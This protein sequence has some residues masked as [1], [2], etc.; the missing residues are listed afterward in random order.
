MSHLSKAVHFLLLVSMLVMCATA[1][2]V[3]RKTPAREKPAEVSVSVRGA[4]QDEALSPGQRR[5]LWLLVELFEEV[6]GCDDKT[7]SIKV[8]AQIAD[9]LWKYDEARAGL[10]FEEA[11][12]AID[13]MKPEPQDDPTDSPLPSEYGLQYQLRQE[14]LEL[15]A[16][17]DSEWAR[18]LGAT[19]DALDRAEVNQTAALVQTAATTTGSQVTA[20]GL[21]PSMKLSSIMKSLR[22]ADLSD[23]LNQAEM[24]RSTA[25]R[26]SYYSRAARQA[27]VENDF[28][29]ALSI[30]VKISPGPSRENLETMAHQRAA[31]AAISKE[32]F[33]AAD[34]HVRHLPNLVQ[35]ATLYDQMVR[36]LQK[37]NDIG[38]A[39]AVL[40]EAEKS[41]GKAKDRP[42]KACALL[43]MAGAAARVDRLRGFDFLKAAIVAINHVGPGSRLLG[44][45][46]RTA[47][48]PDSLPF[49][50]VLPMLARTDFDWVLQLAQSIDKKEFSVLAQLTICRGLLAQF[51][52]AQ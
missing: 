7:F 5:A 12:H 10:Q 20:G 1:Q 34:Q 15:I 8:Q 52:G 30:T 37:R 35:R 49:D 48:D 42:D 46:E 19:A 31:M 17:H 21:T 43:V 41:F 6:K 44:A 50:Q 14:V 24:A 33:E 13:A 22:P 38:H 27:L 9:L 26:N 39:A 40:S 2:S 32:D 3:P 36:A 28:E 18:T 51:R 47:L 29:R 25:E 11:F 23:L 45:A 4:N 16:K